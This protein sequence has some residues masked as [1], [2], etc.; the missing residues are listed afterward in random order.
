MT[1]P[2]TVVNTL[3]Y[4]QVPPK[5]PANAD[6]QTGL[7][8]NS[9]VR[10]HGDPRFPWAEEFNQQAAQIEALNR[11]TATAIVLLGYV[12]GVPKV[13]SVTACGTRITV[14]TFTATPVSTGIVEVTW[15]V[16][17]LPAQLLPPMF[18]LGDDVDA[19]PPRGLW[20]VNG[21]RIK[22]KDAT[23]AFAPIPVIFAVV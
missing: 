15:P 11:V 6:L 5:R 20:I 10:A 8:Q 21:V 14:D 13:L 22:T 12:S 9:T 3:T 7:K 23:G 4:D 19:F 17:T 16:N 2:I 18:W 1:L